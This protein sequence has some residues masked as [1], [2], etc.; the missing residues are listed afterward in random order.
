[1]VGGQWSVVRC[2]I[3]SLQSLINPQSLRHPAQCI[4]VT[5]ERTVYDRPAE[6]VA[7]TLFDGEIGIAPGHVPLIGRLGYGEMRIGRKG[8]V[9]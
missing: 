9:Q 3:L 5:P 4:V 7:L 8:Q 2:L 1:M 6:F